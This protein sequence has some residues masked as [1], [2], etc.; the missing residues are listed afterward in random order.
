MRMWPPSR[1]AAIGQSVTRG[2][3]TEGTHALTDGGRVMR[4]GI[5][6]RD[7]EHL[8][9]FLDENQG[10][11]GFAVRFSKH[12]TDRSVVLQDAAIVERT[13]ERPSAAPA[14]RCT[15]VDPSAEAFNVRVEAIR[16]ISVCVPPPDAYTEPAETPAE[17]AVGL[18][19]L[20]SVDPD[21]VDVPALVGILESDEPAAR[22]DALRALRQLATERPEDCTSAIPAIRSDV[23]GS[24]RHRRANALAT[25]RG[26][27]DE[28]PS[29]IAPLV[30]D[31]RPALGATDSTVRREGVRCIAAIAEKYPGDVK[32]TVPALAAILEDK[33]PGR[34]HAVYTLSR[35][36]TEDPDAVRA[37]T[38]QLG[39]AIRDRTLP[40][41]TRLNATA[42]LGRLVGEDPSVGLEV[43]GP[44][45]TLVDDDHTKLRN[46]AI[47]LLGD[48]ATVHTDVVEPHAPAIAEGLTVD[49]TYTRV[50][51]SAALSR[52]ASDFPDAV[53]P[54]LETFESLLTDDEP[55][56]RENACWALGYLRAGAATDALTDRARRD[57][58]ADV[59]KTASWALDRIEE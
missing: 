37:V 21:A 3:A 30:E 57:E 36:S 39:E 26:I 40:T 55:Q 58:N 15:P 43:V 48:V 23:A 8:T 41:T 16:T 7:V 32:A 24:D 46:N 38:D 47:A 42:A 6:P 45:A 56:V 59:R 51:A 11:A 14:L 12:G 49:D 25:L 29:A 18:R 20:A 4:E 9:S 28:M 22:R 34:N 50:N 19:R 44:V 52:I 33:T 13:V 31:I 54:H 10:V 5:A 35:I 27:G 1:P 53:S 2:E 17:R